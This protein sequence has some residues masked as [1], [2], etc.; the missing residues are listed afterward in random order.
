MHDAKA[1]FDWNPTHEITLHAHRGCRTTHVLVMLLPDG[2]AYTR[3][4]WGGR[5]VPDW[6]RTESGH[7]LL[8]GELKPAGFTVRELTAK[9]RGTGGE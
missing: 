3:E 5:N 6:Q 1:P 2:D 9:E 4:E 7:W 8:H